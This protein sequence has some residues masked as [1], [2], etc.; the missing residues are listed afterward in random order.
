M[1]G[2]LI[3]TRFRT[4]YRLDDRG[5][6][7]EINQWDGGVPPRFHLMRSADGVVCRFRADVPDDIVSRLDESA[8]DEAD[9]DWRSE[10]PRLHRHYA[11]ILMKAGS[12]LRE[13]AG[14]AFLCGSDHAR[15][16]QAV[17]INVG[18][19]DLLRGGL[20][21]WLPDVPHRQPFLATVKD[22]A[23]VSVCA[24]VR[25]SPA[26]HCAGVETKSGFRGQG[27]AA[28]AVASWASAVHRLGALPLYSTSWSN[29]SS[30]RVAERL[31][32]VL[33]ATDFHLT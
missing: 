23:A 20:E 33:I 14:P 4:L 24:S 17:A 15:E 7:L 26:L 30:R 1:I 27:H 22:G 9:G 18:N 19:S 3:Q 31:G 11:H 16:P 29:R 28:S 12:V 25:I 8:R 2:A 21:E 13:W 5:R 6:L 32:L 10:L